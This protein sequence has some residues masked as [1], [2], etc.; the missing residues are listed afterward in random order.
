MKKIFCLP[1]LCMVAAIAFA[2]KETF[3]LVTYAPPKDSFATEWKKDVRETMI[4]YGTTNK[5]N[6]SWCQVSIVKSNASKGSI[7]LDFESK[8]KELVVK[9]YK[10]AD[11]AQE[12]GVQD[13][14]GWKIKSGAVKFTFDN[15]DAM[16]LLTTMSEGSRCVSIVAATNSQ[17]YIKDI[18]ALLASVDLAMPDTVS[19]QTQIINE[20][21]NSILCTWGANANDNSSYRMKNGVMNYISRQYTF[22]A[23]G[24]YS[25]ITKTFDP[26]ME[27]MLLGKETGTYQISGNNLTI[28]PQKSVL[29]GWTKKNG[30]DEW[31]QYVNSQSIALEKTTYKF[32]KYYFSGIQVWNLVLQANKETKRDGY[33]SSNATISNAWYYAPISKNNPKIITPH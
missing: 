30:A 23:N 31:G 9:N 19:K 6:S 17:D 24:G 25:F 15:K 16:V 5:K 7:D 3:D 13:T 29:E 20:D 12:N 33:F 10:P 27:K 2:Q 1:V 32:T 28:T 21:Q 8:W 26:L 18:E 14:A 22:N 4:S 11:K